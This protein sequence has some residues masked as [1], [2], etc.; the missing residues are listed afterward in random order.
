[1]PRQVP[2]STRGTRLAVR[3]AM[4][5]RKKLLFVAAGAATLVMGC[6]KAIANPK[7]P[8]PDAKADAAPDAPHLEDKAK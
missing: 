5:K 1:M 3:D 4:A 6:T 8:P 2:D 7:G